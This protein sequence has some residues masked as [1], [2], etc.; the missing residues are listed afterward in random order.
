[1]S[2]RTQTVES[3]DTSVLE[4]FDDFFFFSDIKKFKEIVRGKGTVSD[5]L[6]TLLV[7]FFFLTVM[8][9]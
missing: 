5:S 6:M 2:R 4:G 9:L 8:K 3:L 1:M 7:T